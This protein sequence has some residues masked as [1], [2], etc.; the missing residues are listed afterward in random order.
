[1]LQSTDGAQVSDS[2]IASILDGS[3]Y[4]IGIKLCTKNNLLTGMQLTY[5]EWDSLSKSALNNTKNGMEHGDADTGC[6]YTSFNGESV[7][8]VKT[9]T[10]TTNE[11]QG[12]S[13]QYGPTGVV[14]VGTGEL[15]TQD[16]F[17]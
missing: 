17:S 13:I 12:I 8:M 10:S 4:P 1:M 5:G 6:T 7:K 11:I 16:I 9:Y 2:G 15:A 14:T 3:D